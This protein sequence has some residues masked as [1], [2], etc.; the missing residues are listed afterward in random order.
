MELLSCFIRK[1]AAG[2]K[3]TFLYPLILW[4]KNGWIKTTTKSGYSKYSFRKVRKK[5]ESNL[6][7]IFNEIRVYIFF[8]YPSFHIQM[9]TCVTHGLCIRKK[10]IKR[11]EGK[12]NDK[13]RMEISFAHL[14]GFVSHI[15]R[16]RQETLFKL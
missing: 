16:H 2:S 13:S 11:T 3:W 15:S 7:R 6:I 8:L 10:G 9:N 14:V 12:M 1:L 5:A 4:V